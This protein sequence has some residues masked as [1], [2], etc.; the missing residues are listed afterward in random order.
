MTGTVRVKDGGTGDV[1]FSVGL[2]FATLSMAADGTLAG[3]F[4]GH[5]VR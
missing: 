3:T 5:P 1:T 4:R 2:P